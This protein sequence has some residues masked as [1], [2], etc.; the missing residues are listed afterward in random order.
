MPFIVFTEYSTST[1]I[2]LVMAAVTTAWPESVYTPFDYL[3]YTHTHSHTHTRARAHTYTHTR[4]HTRT[5]ARTHTRMYTDRRMNSS[6]SLS[7]FL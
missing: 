4:A 5:H 1:D 7:I 3:V 6:L 2:T